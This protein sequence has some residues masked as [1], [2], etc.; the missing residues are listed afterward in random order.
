MD[1]YKRALAW[2]A[3]R[4]AAHG[5][6]APSERNLL[7]VVSKYRP[8]LLIGL[9]GV[10]G[11][12]DEA[13]VREMARHVQRPV[14]FP[15]SN[16]ST[17]SEAVPA[18]LYAWTECR[19]LVATGSPFRDVDCGGQRFR[20]G[21]GN[22]VFVFPGLGLAAIAV[23]AR[24]VTDGMTKVA[25]EA[26]AAQV[27]D[28]ERASGLLFPSVA[29]LRD[30]SFEIAVAVGSQAVRDG[31]AQAELADVARLVRQARW[32]HEYRDYVAD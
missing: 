12:F 2:P 25:S 26:L 18:D 1:D 6:A 24:K 5:L 15:S 23:N 30:V 17:S 16:P 27:T 29:R 20:I 7:S 21:Q 10:A 28:A 13:V 8:T 14:I 4:A 19:C 9:S 3:E 22:N 11:A 31:V 32:S